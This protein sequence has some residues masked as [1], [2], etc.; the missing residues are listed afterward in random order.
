MKRFFTVIVILIVAALA[1][2]PIAHAFHHHEEN[3][4]FCAFVSSLR[5]KIV[6]VCVAVTFSL[7]MV[8]V[9]LPVKKDICFTVFNNT[10]LNL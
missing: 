9:A 10:R 2:F 4:E 8:S 1:F 7:A 3:C 6:F 5:A